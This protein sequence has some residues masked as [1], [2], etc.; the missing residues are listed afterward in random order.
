[1]PGAPSTPL[2]LYSEQE[3]CSGAKIFRHIIREQT[4]GEPGAN[5]S[6][7]ECKDDIELRALPPKAMV[8]FLWSSTLGKAQLSNIWD[9]TVGKHKQNFR[10]QDFL[11]LLRLL[12]LAQNGVDLDDMRIGQSDFPYTA[13]VSFY[14]LDY[15]PVDSQVVSKNVSFEE[16]CESDPAEMISSPMKFVTDEGN[17]SCPTSTTHETTTH[18]VPSTTRASESITGGLQ[19][20]GPSGLSDMGIHSKISDETI[21]EESSLEKVVVPTA[22]I[23]ARE[24][25]A[26]S[27]VSVMTAPTPAMSL[28]HPD[29]QGRDTAI[30]MVNGVVGKMKEMLSI[31]AAYTDSAGGSADSRIHSLIAEIKEQIVNAG[32]KLSKLI[33]AGQGSMTQ[34]LEIC[35]KG[36][37]MISRAGDYLE[38][39]VQKLTSVMDTFID[40]GRKI[41]C[42]LHGRD[43]H[44]HDPASTIAGFRDHY[45]LNFMPQKS[46]SVPD[47]DIPNDDLGGTTTPSPV[48]ISV[49]TKEDQL[50]ERILDFRQV[51]D[52][53]VGEYQRLLASQDSLLK[54][55]SPQATNYRSFTEE[56]NSLRADFQQHQDQVTSR[57]AELNGMLAEYRTLFGEVFKQMYSASFFRSQMV[58][59]TIALANDVLN[60]L[61][62]RNDSIMSTF[63]EA[64]HKG[65]A[66][67][68]ARHQTDASVIRLQQQP[69]L[70]TNKLLDQIRGIVREELHR[71]K[72]DIVADIRQAL[73]LPTP[74]HNSPA[75]VPLGSSVLAGLSTVNGTSYPASEDGRLTPTVTNS[76]VMEAFAANI[77]QP[78]H[79][80]APSLVSSGHSQLPSERR[81]SNAEGLMKLW[82]CSAVEK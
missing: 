33:D 72:A 45:P 13:D 20:V 2:S 15:T 58:S 38:E 31:I 77:Y 51:L 27:T 16:P 36:L 9:R 30:S 76:T 10:L 34:S 44:S 69:D 71:M 48:T 62:S 4:G 24:P 23:E 49:H 82:E 63:A 66:E 41:S 46:F 26:L 61:Y 59:H 1:M 67:H 68:A 8:D 52:T 32:G 60:E 42:L 53:I 12:A 73:V 28:N 81:P 74:L 40:E 3:R 78:S 5:S 50:M 18:E 14:G 21:E 22:T 75:K 6:L 54:V 19:I 79:G 25:R 39:R 11:H 57:T 80:E 7:S 29:Q 37:E 55:L 65:V 47:L 64:V 56:L 17:S 43:E 70:T 35:N